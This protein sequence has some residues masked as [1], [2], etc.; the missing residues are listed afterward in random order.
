MTI[1]LLYI[2]AGLFTGFLAGLLGLGGAMILVPLLISTF[3]RLHFPAEHIYVMAVGTTFANIL[4]TSFSSL[5]AHHRR[6]GVLWPVFRTL[7]PGI[8]IGTL[9]GTTLAAHAPGKFL[10]GVFVC[11]LFWIATRMLFRKKEASTGRL[12]GPGRMFGIG[13]GIGGFCS[14]IGAGGGTLVVPLVSRGNVKFSQAIG[15]AAAVGFPIA[16][17]GVVGYVLNGLR[18]T[19]LPPYSLGYVYLPALI[20]LTGA[21]MLAAPFGVRMAHRLPVD[22]LRMIFAVLLYVLAVKMAMGLL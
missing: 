3:S 5:M 9:A 20:G 21:A 2:S 22:R 10:E 12:P 14:L 17:S 16:L 4:F 6:G 11:F 8:V 15:T 13:I 1:W 19:D 7:A 18:A